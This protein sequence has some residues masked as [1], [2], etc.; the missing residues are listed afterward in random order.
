MTEENKDTVP[1]NEVPSSQGGAAE[2][3]VKMED[4]SAEETAAPK[5]IKLEEELFA[6]DSEDDDF[7]GEKEKSPDT[8]TS[9]NGETKSPLPS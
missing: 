4:A 2:E 1:P 9:R 7:S 8:P 3:D 5:D 6:T